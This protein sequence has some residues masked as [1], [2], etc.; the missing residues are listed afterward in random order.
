MMARIRSIHPDACKSRKLAKVT[1]EAERCWWRLQVHCDDDGRCEDDPELLAAL[2]FS[3]QRDVTAEDVDGW[4]FEL[5]G[6]GLIDRYGDDEPVLVVR[7]FKLYQKPRHPQA[8]KLPEPPDQGITAFRRLVTAE[9]GNAPAGVVGV[10][11]EGLDRNTRRHTPSERKRL[12]HQTA[13][14][15]AERRHLNEVASTKNDPDR[16]YSATVVGIAKDI[17]DEFHELLSSSPG[18]SP[19]QFADYFQPPDAGIP[20]RPELTYCDECGWNRSAHDLP[21]VFVHSEW[22]AGVGS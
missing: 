17:E 11:E 15:I 12:L 3:M 14:V 18:S 1:A 10:E 8:S 22:V 19:E 4:L 16:W 13:S 6:A 2:L 5:A 9:C 7:Q 21:H 20:Q